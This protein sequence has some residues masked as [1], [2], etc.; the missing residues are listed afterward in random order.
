MT[1]EEEFLICQYEMNQEMVKKRH[2]MVMKFDSEASEP[3]VLSAVVITKS[4]RN[5]R[6]PNELRNG[7]WWPKL[8]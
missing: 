8:G 5:K 4:Y 1:S 3:A 7:N 2:L 6:G